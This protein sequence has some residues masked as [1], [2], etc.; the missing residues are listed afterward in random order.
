MLNYEFHCKRETAKL[1][2]GKQIL[3]DLG[4]KNFCICISQTHQFTAIAAS[5]RLDWKAI[6]FI[7]LT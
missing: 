3:T 5:S 4:M 2:A 7:L 6:N 1:R